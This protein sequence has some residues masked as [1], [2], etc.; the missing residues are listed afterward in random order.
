MIL[1]GYLNARLGNPRDEHEGD[2]ATALADQGLV[3]MTDYL[4]PRRQYRGAGGWTWSM[5]RDRIQ[6]TGRGNYILFTDRRI[7]S[8]PG[9]RRHVMEHTTG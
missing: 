7:F 2:L 3:N 5:Q 8:T 4:L 6:V 1:M 9:Y